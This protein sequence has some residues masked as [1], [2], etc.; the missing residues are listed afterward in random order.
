MLGVVLG[1]M[2]KLWSDTNRR[3][4]H[5]EAGLRAEMRAMRDE[6]KGDIAAVRAELKADIATVRAEFHR[7]VSAVRTDTSASIERL[8]DR[9]HADSNAINAR[10][11]VLLLTRGSLAGTPEAAIASGAQQPAAEAGP[12]Y[13]VPSPDDGG[14]DRP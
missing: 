10:L 7:E 4:D 3:S 14:S 12:E 5:L 1:V 2:L 8:S 13:R 9:Q 11:D 6:L